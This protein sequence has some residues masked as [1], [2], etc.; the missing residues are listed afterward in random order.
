[1]NTPFIPFPITPMLPADI[2]EVIALEQAAYGSHWSARNYEHELGYNHLAH[3]Y[4]MRP[5]LEPTIIGHGGFWLMAD[6]IHIIT[7]AVRPAWRGRGLGEWLLLHLLEQG[8]QLGAVVATLEVRAANIVAINL[9]AK[10]G[11][12]EVGRRSRYYSNHEDALILTTPEFTAP[13]YQALLGQRKASLR[14]RL[15]A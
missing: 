14:Q 11:F 4:V 1:M 5:A 8:R 6:E 7:V 3:Y 12:R 15:A 2:A 9:Y 10:F 13:G